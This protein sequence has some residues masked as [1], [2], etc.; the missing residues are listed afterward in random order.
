[1]TQPSPVPTF[2]PTIAARA[3]R[4]APPP[5]TPIWKG[6]QMKG[7]FINT[8]CLQGLLDDW[9]GPV[10]GPRGIPSMFVFGVWC[11]WRGDHG[12]VNRIAW[13][14]GACFTAAPEDVAELRLDTRRPEVYDHLDRQ[15]H[16]VFGVRTDD[17]FRWAS[18]VGCWVMGEAPNRASWKP[19][20]N[21]WDDGHAR[22]QTGNPLKDLPTPH[23]AAEA[24]A[25]VVRWVGEEVR[26]G[27]LVDHRSKT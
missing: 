19:G 6:S 3:S 11:P 26:A 27:R 12:I 24:L 16:G 7:T 5:R 13:I 4:L 2:R 22:Y 10:E 25:A 23:T 21:C 20:V 17:R 18:D 8:S 9:C 1:M 15:L 14:D